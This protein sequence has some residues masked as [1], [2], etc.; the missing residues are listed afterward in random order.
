[1]HYSNDNS[2]AVMTVNICFEVV[3]YFCRE[4]LSRG[5]VMDLDFGLLT[6]VT[7]L[8]DDVPFLCCPSAE[9]PCSSPRLSR[10]TSDGPAG[11]T[12]GTESRAA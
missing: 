7:T 5:K 1:M 4:C 9:L 10:G 11:A 6:R 2:R 3:C 8:T 12:L